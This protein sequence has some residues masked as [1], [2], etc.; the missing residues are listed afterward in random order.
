[1]NYIPNYVENIVEPFV[2][3][4]DLIKFVEENYNIS[5]YSFELYDI[6]P[7]IKNT[8]ERDSIK[9]PPN[10]NNKFILTNPPYLARNKSK[11]KELFD[12]AYTI[13]SHLLD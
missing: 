10:Y 12:L 2:G 1:M 11:D 8:I 13:I 6:D 3:K 5:N 4:G 7:K 9:N